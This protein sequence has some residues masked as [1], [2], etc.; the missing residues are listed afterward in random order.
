MM[1][2]RM[3]VNKSDAITT[4]NTG[5]FNFFSE[6]HA[7]LTVLVALKLGGP[8]V[9]RVVTFSVGGGEVVGGKSQ[10]FDLR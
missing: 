4:S 2:V 6:T 9:V 7:T 8:F 3:T 1:Q 5:M 10:D